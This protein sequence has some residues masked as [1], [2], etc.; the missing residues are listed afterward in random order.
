[1]SAHAPNQ[2]IPVQLP[3]RGNRIVGS[4]E[5]YD[6]I[7]WVMSCSRS[8][9]KLGSP[10]SCYPGDPI[11]MIIVHLSGKTSKY[12]KPC[13]RSGNRRLGAHLFLDHRL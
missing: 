6:Q 8:K 13:P 1:M 12:G 5:V 4:A 2:R 11:D 7:P 3:V 10:E 9:P